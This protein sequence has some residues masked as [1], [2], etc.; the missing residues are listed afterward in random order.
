[1]VKISSQLE[2][3][4][5]LV[6]KVSH[7][8]FWLFKPIFRHLDPESGSGSR[9]KLNVDPDSKHCICVYEFIPATKT[10]LVERMKYSHHDPVADILCSVLLPSDY[11]RNILDL[12]ALSA[13]G[14][15]EKL[16]NRKIILA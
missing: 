13:V 4:S 15:I 8:I 2:H 9:L 1:V 10:C 3:F 14:R 16:I 6:L 11:N 7:S 12:L 5:V